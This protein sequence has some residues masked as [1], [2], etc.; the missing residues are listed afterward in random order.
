[1]VLPAGDGAGLARAILRYAGDAALWQAACER[2]VA[3]AAEWNADSAAAAF[4][5]LAARLAQP[6]PAAGGAADARAVPVAAP[7]VLGAR[8]GNCRA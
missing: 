4:M 3:A 7:A 5:A 1:M 8:G 6:H 2:A